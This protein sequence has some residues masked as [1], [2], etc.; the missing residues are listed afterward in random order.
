M[1]EA[2]AGEVPASALRKQIEKA[3][4]ERIE[5]NEKVWP[6][7]TGVLRENG[8]TGRRRHLLDGMAI[9]EDD[10]PTGRV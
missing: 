3:L 9:E 2:I 5:V 7:H 6:L 10:E 8:H 1:R 4:A